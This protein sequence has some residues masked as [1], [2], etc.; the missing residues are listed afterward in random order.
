VAETPRFGEV[1]GALAAE[2]AF[3]LALGGYALEIPGATLVTHEKLPGPRFNFVTVRAVAVDRQAAFFERTLD[4]YFQRALRPRFRVPEPVAPH[5]DQGLRRFAFRPTDARQVLWIGG[6]ASEGR[7]AGTV[8]P[9]RATDAEI[10]LIASFWTEPKERPELRS[11]LDVAIHH[12]VPSETLEPLL[13]LREGAPVAAALRYCAG[14][15]AGLHLVATVPA[16]RGEGAAS[17]LVDFALGRVREEPTTRS[18]LIADAVPDE[19][20]LRELGFAPAAT[21]V[22]YELP[23]DAELALPPPGPA[24]PPHWRPPR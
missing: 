5:L 22:E 11:A 19:R 10:E 13:A 16:A 4:H 14:G 7:L 9:R 6:P 2:R 23:A 8:T 15:F 18:F 20:R 17:A 12:P 1:D 3:V 24:G 21:W